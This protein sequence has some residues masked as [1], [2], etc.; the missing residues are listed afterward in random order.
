VSDRPTVSVIIPAYNAAAHL[1]EALESLLR[2]T[3]PAAEIIVVDDGSTDGTQQVLRGYHDS[4][5]TI[6]QENTGAGAARNRGLSAAT[7][8]YV[9][10]M[11]ADDVCAP[12]RLQQQVAA[13][14]RTPEAI[15]CFTG[16]WQFDASGRFAEQAASSP[17]AD[18]DSLD[19]LSRCQFVIASLMFD[20][21][22]AEGIRFPEDVRAAG[23]DIIFSALLAARGCMIAVPEALYGYRSHS[24]QWSIKNR[25][26]STSNLF[27]EYRYN[28][29]KT[30][31]HEYW[32]ERGWE[33][34]ER[35]LWEGLVQQTEDAYW[36]RY[37]QF[38]LHDR[39]YMRTH[40]PSRLPPPAVLRWRWYPGWLWRA[41]GRLDRLRR[42]G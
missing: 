32:P 41:K 28:W 3:Y 22:R 11:D 8:K 21:A 27:F 10:F 33:E 37:K 25:A 35:K 17:P 26:S 19:F 16:Y 38:F 13:L 15:A 12:E 9:A 14:Q 40:W 34:L 7:G 1:G 5:R 24:A 18:A 20:R 2:Q 29:A 30:H 31:W 39:N 36:G 42:H 4:V 23:E 6:R